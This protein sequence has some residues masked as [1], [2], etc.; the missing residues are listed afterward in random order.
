MLAQ[1][2]AH[3]L[4]VQV[5]DAHGRDRTVRVGKRSRKQVGI[6]LTATHGWYD[7]LVTVADHPLV[8]RALAGRFDNGR[9]STSDP[10]LGR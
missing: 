3:G 2:D 5:A 7:V 6:G 10:Q 4:R 8:K 9:P 1:V